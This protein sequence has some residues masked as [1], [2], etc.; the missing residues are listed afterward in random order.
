MADHDDA[1]KVAS[2]D[3][4]WK[5]ASNDDARKAASDDVLS[6][7]NSQDGVCDGHTRNEQRR[8]CVGL[9]PHHEEGRPMCHWTRRRQRATI[10]SQNDAQDKGGWGASNDEA[11][12]DEG[13][14]VASQD[15]AQKEAARS[16]GRGKGEE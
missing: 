11:Q 1:Q 2:H 13:H 8:G 5:A 15:G 12:G 7:D 14:R 4:A 6:Q 9:H 3:D 10:L 16:S